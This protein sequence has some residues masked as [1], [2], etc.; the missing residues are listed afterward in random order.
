MSLSLTMGEVTGEAKTARPTS[1]FKSLLVDS[2]Y[3]LK[4]NT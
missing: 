4:L 3:P 2:G 1:V